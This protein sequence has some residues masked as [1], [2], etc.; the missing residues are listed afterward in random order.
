MADATTQLLQILLQETGSHENAWGTLLNQGLQK[1][2]D[3]IAGATS[4]TSTGSTIVLSDDQARPQTILVS[5]ALAT[6]AV[7]VVPA[8]FKSWL[9]LNATT[10]DH[11]VFVRCAAESTGFILQ[12]G[13]PELLWCDGGQV[14]L[15]GSAG[16]VPVGT[17]LDIG[18]VAAPA[19][20]LIC[21][22]SN[23]SRL[24]YGRLFSII[25]TRFGAGDGLNTF[26]IPNGLGRYRRGAAGSGGGDIGTYLTAQVESHIHGATAAAVGDHT[27]GLST[28]GDHSHAIAGSAGVGGASAGVGF[29]NLNNLAPTFSAGAHAHTVFGA[30]GHGHA[31]TISAYGADETRPASYVTLPIVRFQ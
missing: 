6:D 17:V 24:T 16:Q 4:L 2:E 30:G 12:R 5:G 10:G 8:R 22:G 20:Y 19:N 28:D 21:D 27:H 1:L 25:G 14:N 11:M 15:V 29:Q 3:A 31:I 9:F 7:I 13:Q 26:A 23:V 18:G